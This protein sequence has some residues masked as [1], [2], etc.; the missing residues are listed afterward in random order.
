[1]NQYKMTPTLE[2]AISKFQYL[3]QQRDPHV[4]VQYAFTDRDIQLHIRWRGGYT[5]AHVWEE[6]GQ[7][8]GYL[9]DT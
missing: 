8:V 6:D 2:E 3:L 4:T 9:Y 1:M 7:P 5:L